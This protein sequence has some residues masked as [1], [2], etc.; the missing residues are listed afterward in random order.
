MIP[1]LSAACSLVLSVED[2]VDILS[3]TSP[4]GYEGR[5]STFEL[6]SFVIELLCLVEVKFLQVKEIT[7]GQK[8]V[9]LLE[10]RNKWRKF[11]FCE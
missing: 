7:R 4:L 10:I 2:L 5:I 1:A 3:C 8:Y 9:S 6:A 11:R